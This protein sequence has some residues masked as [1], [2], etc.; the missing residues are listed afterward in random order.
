MTNAPAGA[1]SIAAASTIILVMIMLTWPVILAGRAGTSEER[2]Q[3]RYHLPVVRTMV[4]QWPAVDLVHYRST[5]SPGYH[6]LLAGVVSVVGDDVVVLQVVSCLLS[7][8]LVLVVWRWAATRAGPWVSA[9]LVLPLMTSSYVLGAAIWLTT[10]NAALLFVALALGLSVFGRGGPGAG[11]LGAIWATAAVAVRQIHI[12]S[13]AAPILR[14]LV[15]WRRG[16]CTTRQALAVAPALALPFVLVVVFY[17]M[18]GGLTPPAYADIHDRGINPAS[19]VVILALMGMYGV[20]FL[21][22]FVTNVRQL[23]PRDPGGAL[24][25]AGGIVVGLLIPSTYDRDAGR[26]G[27]A[28]WELARRVPE[29]GGRAI[30]FPVACGVGAFVLWRAVTRCR[31][32]GSGSGLLIL[33]ITSFGWMLAQAVNS[34]AWQRY[35]EPLVLIILAWLFALARDHSSSPRSAWGPVLL[36]AGLLGLSVI[37]VYLPAFGG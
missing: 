33:G 11:A 6:L 32:A 27:G 15:D 19:I 21:P 35:C 8:S 29:I 28:I 37:Q 23:V 17:L 12:W 1:R 30:I 4:A 31:A 9:G 3:T 14:V 36:G 5:T 7:I 18:W 26:W 25:V 13:A 22:A 34:Q 24:A 10:D 2:D 16:D 20:F